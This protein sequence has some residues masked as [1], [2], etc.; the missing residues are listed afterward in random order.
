MKNVLLVEVC[1]ACLNTSGAP[2]SPCEPL[3]RSFQQFQSSRSV[4]QTISDLPF[5]IKT[6]HR[7]NFK[8]INLS[9]V[10]SDTQDAWV[11]ANQVYLS[12]LWFSP[13]NVPYELEEQWKLDWCL[14]NSFGEIQ[15]VC[16][17]KWEIIQSE[18][19]ALWPR[20][21]LVNRVSV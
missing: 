6:F 12:F 2:E 8:V 13:Y 10:G 1:F 17:R 18:R 16:H 5:S 21:W 15:S 14:W 19:L 4:V 20:H 3:I 9:V 11:Q 7:N